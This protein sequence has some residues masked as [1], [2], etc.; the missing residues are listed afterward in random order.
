MLNAIIRF[1]LNNRLIILIGALILF[2][3]G[4]YNMIRMPVD[5]FPDLTAP[6]VTVM[7]EAPGY[8]PE[9]VE[10][11]VTFPL[12]AALNGAPNVR[13]VRS[14]SSAG[15]SVIWVE[16]NWGEDIYRSRQIVNERLQ[17]VSLPDEIESPQMGTIS[18]IMGEI[19]YLAVTA[20]ERS[21]EELRRLSEINIVRRLLAIPGISKVT[22][23]GGN[24]RE[25]QVVA[26][27]LALGQYGISLDL[28]CRR[29]SAGSDNPAAGFH[30]DNRSEYRVRGLGRARTTEDLSATVLTVN[31]GIPVTVRDVA[32]VAIGNEPKRGDG[33]YKGEPAVVISIQKQ[34]G[35]NTIALTREIDRTLK[36][37]ADSLPTDIHL[38]SDTFRQADFIRLSIH[39]IST[40]L[41]DGAILVVIILFLFLGTFRSTLISALAIPLSLVGGILAISAFGLTINTMTLGGLTIAIG[42]LV[43]DAIIDVENVFRRLKLERRKPPIRQRPALQI[44][45]EASSEV[46][47]AILFATLI[48]LMV[49]LPLFFLPG[50]EGRLLRPLALAYGS[51]LA[52]SLIVSLTVTPVLASF[53]LKGPILERSEPSLPRTLKE[54]YTKILRF[55]LNHDRSVLRA[56]FAVSLL[57]MAT[58]PFLGHS[59]LP[60]FNEGAFTVTMSAPPGITLEE[61][62]QLG[63]RVEKT[64]LQFGEVVSTSRRTGRAEEDEHALSINASEIEVVLNAGTD[65]DDLLAKMRKAVAP[66]PG[67]NVVFGQPISHRIDHMISGSKTNLAVKVFG[68]DL[69]VLRKLTSEIERLLQ[70]IPGV[71]DISNQEQIS[72]PQLIIDY[73]RSAMSRFGMTP[74]GL[75]QTVE[76]LFQGTRVG[77]IVEDGIASGIVVKYQANLR[78]FREKLA[79]L[80]VSTDAGKLVTLSDVSDIRFDLGPS[81]IRRENVQRLAMLTANISGRDKAGTAER[82]RETIQQKVTFPAGYHMMLGGQFEEATKSFRNILLMSLVVLILIY[83][84]LYMALRDHIHAAI[85]LVNLPL[86]LIGGVFAIFLGY[87]VLSVASLVGFITLF[88]IATRNGVLLVNHYQHLIEQEQA[89][90]DQAV[91]RGSVERLIPVLMTALT[92][93]LALVPLVVE[94]MDAGNEIQSPMGH[95]ILGGL[96]TSTF[97]NMIIVPILFKKWGMKSYRTEPNP[98]IRYQTSK[99][100]SE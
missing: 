99:E 37:I 18:S 88:G 62:D 43:D 32:T 85:V 68:P 45:F 49:F 23:I 79:S 29:L 36:E 41:R 53:L 12:E 98:D 76:A 5:V 34:P 3:S 26:D 1:S 93:G 61:S 57:A 24:V 11:L 28:L 56:T 71:V 40:A 33:S 60:E 54:R 65:R 2:G 87:G 58:I 50:M 38:Q 86:A 66:I 90:L 51:A 74:Q 39:N 25:Y 72:V 83:F 46:R 17:T 70:N 47:T 20:T 42:A 35:V 48:I 8:A 81:Q 80:P 84:L 78:K 97:L 73:D 19:M 95:V 89:T 63:S 96:L 69:A 16:F 13:R 59:F 77:H 82:V 22:P 14:V 75:S 91:L 7:T 55:V 21:P 52:I 44:V 94:G 6:T 10:L 92:T 27:P 67:I 4:I 100:S 9:E 30:V 31:G 64:L 15:I